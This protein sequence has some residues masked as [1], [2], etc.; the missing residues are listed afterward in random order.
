MVTG[1]RIVLVGEVTGTAVE[2]DMAQI[3]GGA[4]KSAVPSAPRGGNSKWPCASYRPAQCA[5]RSSARL[6]LQD[7]ATAHRLVVDDA[8]I[9][10]I[11]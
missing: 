9:G 7:A 11:V 4:C 2:M 8:V 10:H 3:F 6:P 5:R 1:G